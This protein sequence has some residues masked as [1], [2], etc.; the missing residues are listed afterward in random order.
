MKLFSAYRGLSEGAGRAA[1]RLPATH[2]PLPRVGYLL[3]TRRCNLAC[4]M[5]FLKAHAGGPPSA[6]EL[7][8]SEWVALIRGLPRP[9]LLSLTG[10]EPLLHPAFHDI[11]QA[12]AAR[13]PVVLETNATRLDAAE[14]RWL[15]DHSPL[16][17][18]AGLAVLSV[19]IHGPPAVHDRLVGRAGAFA[20]A[21]AGVQH[22][23][24]LR[25]RRGF[26]RIALRAVVQPETL[27]GL[28][29]LPALARQMGADELVLSVHGS[30]PDVMDPAQPSSCGSASLPTP[31]AP[32][33]LAPILEQVLASP[34][35]PVQINPDGPQPEIVGLYR[36]IWDPAAHDCLFP[37]M[38]FIVSAQGDLGVCPHVW[39]GSL[40]ERSFRQVWNGEAAARHRRFLRA[41]GE[42]PPACAG[43]CS[44]MRRR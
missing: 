25:G 11:F 15:L 32:E 18:A 35:V 21:A 36:G 20:E 16:R 5:C 22:V 23:A 31:I 37:W 8:G 4:A 27:A 24:R 44:R 7:T 39:V 19:S 3:L 29:A 9:A 13:G 41:A 30:A 12:A 40:R 38:R 14:A 28:T 26:P 43:C 42:L 10:G 34:E 33:E 17:P 1:R 2:A 6:P